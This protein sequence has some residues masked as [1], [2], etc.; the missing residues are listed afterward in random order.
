VIDHR[1][2]EKMFPKLLGDLSS[3]LR[4]DE[5]KESEEFHR[6]R[7]VRPCLGNTHAIYLEEQKL[8]D[9]A[10]KRIIATLAAEMSME[11]VVLTS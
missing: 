6:C 5:G 11:P 4:A 9:D 1:K 7:R 3:N 10:A 2:I 8:P